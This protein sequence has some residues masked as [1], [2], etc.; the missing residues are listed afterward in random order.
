M[1][2]Q[3]CN[4]CLEIREFNPYSLGCEKCN[5]TNHYDEDRNEE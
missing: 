5:D 1:L 3:E 2:N 4:E